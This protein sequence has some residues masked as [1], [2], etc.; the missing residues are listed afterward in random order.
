VQAQQRASR[1]TNMTRTW[2]YCKI[3]GC[4]AELD[5]Q[6]ISQHGLEYGRYSTSCVVTNLCKALIL[7]SANELKRGNR[8]TY[9]MT[10]PQGSTMVQPK[11]PFRGLSATIRAF[12]AEMCR[13]SFQGPVSHALLLRLP[14]VAY[15]N[16][17][18]P[19]MILTNLI[20]ATHL[21]MSSY[22]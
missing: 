15:W 6:R 5:P 17:E 7:A 10:D 2:A 20:T 3:Q 1:M 22:I 4:I 11:L 18:V 14:N 8:R 19:M 9:R 16:F 13:S 12:R 21:R